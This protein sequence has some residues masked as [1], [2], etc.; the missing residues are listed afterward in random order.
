MTRGWLAS[1]RSKA[2]SFN[3][4][5]DRLQGAHNGPAAQVKELTRR[6]RE[7]SLLRE[8]DQ[9]LLAGAPLSDILSSAVEA[10]VVLAEAKS[11]VVVTP[12]PK[13]KEL[14]P[15][16]I[17]A[18]DPEGA[19][20]YFTDMRL[21]VGE[22]A[23]GQAIATRETVSSPDISNDPYMERYRDALLAL[24]IRA[25]LAVPLRADDQILGA[26][27]IGYPTVRTF[28]EAEIRTMEG[29][30]NQLAVVLEYAR[31][32]EEGRERWQLKEAARLKTLFIANMSHELR[33]P[34]HSI[35]GFS[36]LLQDAVFGTLND[37]QRRYV[38]HIRSSGTH[39][40]A[41]IE[42]I[43]DLSKVE[44]G[45]IELRREPLLLADAL[46]SA[47]EL[48]RGQA[49]K[50]GI[51]LELQVEEE[52]PP[53]VADPVRLRQ[54]LFNLLSNAVKFTRESG[55]I[56][57]TAKSVRNGDN[58]E[59]VEIAITDSGIGIQPDDLPKLFHPFVRLDTALGAH[60]KGTGL[61][62]ALTRRLV[63]LHGGQI[64]AASEGEGRGST[65]T[66]RLP[67]T[68]QSASPAQQGVGVTRHH[69]VM[70]T[71]APCALSVL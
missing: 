50:Q 10:F 68:P 70:S 32:R 47:V 31:L 64:V 20:R 16:A 40:L 59:W 27:G 58:T 28:S 35:L 38:G 22:G 25:I 53:I 34:L 13:S 61:G 57:V 48:L 44:A 9:K 30:A 18:P 3:N 1:I 60:T 54:I 26:V 43:L 2:G 36:E 65:F 8:I 39:L 6:E 29:F 71:D 49:I 17:Y 62:L 56:A 67:R 42:H 24:N 14:M 4:M 55:W 51:A 41:L 52:L 63:E 33:T 12:D 5:M 19:R 7:L 46:E 11:G 69:H 21:C 23:L 45:K 37:K 15:I 66:V